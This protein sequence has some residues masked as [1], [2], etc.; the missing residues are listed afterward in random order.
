[1]SPLPN[2]FAPAEREDH[3]SILNDASFFMKHKTLQDL[4]NAVPYIGL[5]LNE[6]RQLVYS[7]ENLLETIGVSGIEK[8]LGKRP[9]EILNCINA[10]REPGGC[11]TSE[12]CQVCG[13]VRVIMESMSTGKQVAG[14]CRITSGNGSFTRAWDFRCIATPFPI[15]N[16]VYTVVSL[17]DISDEKRRRAME[18]IFFHDLINTATGLDGF[19][20]YIRETNQ[21]EDTKAHLD[22]VR[23]LS[24]SLIDEILAQRQ[25]C[26]AENDELF[27][28]KEDVYTLDFMSDVVN[29]MVYHIL[30]RNKTITIDEESDNVHF[31]SDRALLRRVLINMLKN[32]LEACKK[33]EEVKIGCRVENGRIIF[34]V[35]NQC[36]IEPDVQKQIFQRS[37]STK[38]DDRGLGTYSMRLLTEKYLGGKVSF[39]SSH[40]SGTA[41]MI[42]LPGN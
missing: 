20:D 39:K 15:N 18:R 10:K 28:R 25:L 29:Y 33:S 11:G 38:G 9:G 5:I 23:R 16:R 30:A 14:E 27:V 1:M 31:L 4:L 26:N 8:L 41:F 37:F 19:I 40:E 24:K 42:D 3:Q 6:H 32:A 21:Q 13:A 12:F 2:H 22:I 36:Y 17:I 35:H 34:W 7:N